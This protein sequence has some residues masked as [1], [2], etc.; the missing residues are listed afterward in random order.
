MQGPGATALARSGV[1][2][3]VGLGAL[4]ALP[5]LADAD[6]GSGASGGS[7]GSAAAVPDLLTAGWWAGVA[8]L[9]AQA[10]VLLWSTAA[11][12][13]TAVAAA[14]VVLVARPVG[15]DDATSLASLAV[16]VAVYLAVTALGVE[17]TWPAL[18]AA[19]VSVGVGDNPAQGVAVVG[20]AT[21]VAL[22]VRSRRETVAARDREAQ[23]LVREQDA[24]T[25][26]A[27]ARERTAMARELHD[28]AAHHL[29]GIAVMTAAIGRQIETDPAGARAA[30]AEVRRQSMKVLDDLRSLVGLLRADDQGGGMVRSE[31]LAGVPG[32]VEEYAQR[33]VPVRLTVLDPPPAAEVGEVGP[34]AQ[35]AAYR[36]VQEALANATRHA[37]GAACEVVVDGRDGS[38][39][40][41]TVRNDAGAAPSRVG[42]RPGFGLVGM[43]ER[44]ELT[45]ARLEAGAT[46]EGG[47][48]VRLH[49]PREPA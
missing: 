35:L 47:W 27:I 25:E 4:V 30:V 49:V 41:V 44:A 23:A 43:R 22:V 3:A 13:V 12:R 29:S 5:F 15:M 20:S 6:A 14:L 37:P 24:L 16:L 45:G 28:I 32:L 21:V 18:V 9:T 10:V 31:S 40:V 46:P 17:R 33:S 19:L 11:P 8:V 2:L 39:V 34:L 38:E 36:M 48:Q 1:C 7:G 26:A 42:G